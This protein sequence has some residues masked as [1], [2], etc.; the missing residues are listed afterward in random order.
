MS[1]EKRWITLVKKS[2][3]LSGFR[4]LSLLKSHLSTLFN[5]FTETMKQFLLRKKIKLFLTIDTLMIVLSDFKNSNETST[6]FM[7]SLCQ[8]PKTAVQT[9]S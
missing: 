5:D 9:F 6:T 4:K 8:N 2:H 7:A 1:Y 3:S